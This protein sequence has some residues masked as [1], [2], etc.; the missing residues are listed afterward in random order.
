MEKN[1]SCFHCNTFS[2]CW[3]RLEIERVLLRGE[4]RMINIDDPELPAKF[5][6]MFMTLG[7]ACLYFKVKPKE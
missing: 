6:D 3:L 4:L 1:R 5:S 2:F 7:N